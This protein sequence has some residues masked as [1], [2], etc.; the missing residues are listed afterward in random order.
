MAFHFQLDF[1]VGGKGKQHHYAH[2]EA[3]WQ[4][5]L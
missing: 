1:A 2:D 5:E 4:L 3:H